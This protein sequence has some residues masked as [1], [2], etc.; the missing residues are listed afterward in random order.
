VLQ[1]NPEVSV[2]NEETEE[3]L[4]NLLTAVGWL[5]AQQG[6]EGRYVIKNPH[7]LKKKKST[8]SHYFHCLS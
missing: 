3:L 7:I 6:V 1:N 8:Y 5:I 2:I 4:N